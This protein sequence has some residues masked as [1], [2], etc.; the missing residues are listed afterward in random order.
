MTLALTLGQCSP[1]IGSA[2]V[3]VLISLFS[4]STQEIPAELLLFV[5]GQGESGREV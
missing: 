1:R 2:V 4:F 5:S 3:W